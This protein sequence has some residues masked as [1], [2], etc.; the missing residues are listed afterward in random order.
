MRALWPC[1][2]ST[3][4]VTRRRA[5]GVTKWTGVREGMHGDGDRVHE[6]WDWAET[7]STPG[8]GTEQRSEI[9]RDGRGTSGQ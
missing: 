5:R 1:A 9:G 4:G 8:G 6:L 3:K 7:E 2:V